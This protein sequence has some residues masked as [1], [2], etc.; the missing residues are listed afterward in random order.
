MLLRNLCLVCLS[1]A[2]APSSFA[3]E[4]K[5]Q[6]PAGGMRMPAPDPDGTAG[7]DAIFDGK[8]LNGWDGDTNFWRAEG[9]AIAGETTA[10]KP[11]KQNTFLIWRGGA[12]KDFELKLEYRINSTNSGIQ[13][14]SVEVP[15]DVKWVLKGY[16]ADIDA[17]NR[18]TGQLYEER[19]RGF[20]AL[21][22]QFTRILEPKKQTLIGSPGDGE[23]LKAFIKNDDWNE[24]HVI[25][26][27]NNI[28]HVMNG[29]VMSMVVDDDA[30]NRAME[31]LLGFQLH[32]GPPMKV[33]FR[34]IF[35][36]KL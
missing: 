9:G 1:L 35:L 8:T 19:G 16:Q 34:K 17:Q 2:L 30:Q 7:F 33:E 31:G 11:L 36:R 10:A 15:G 26:R 29:H 25:A 24:F 18:Y 22:G 32:V 21:R 23:A 12:P 20:L 5:G 14:R 13:Y 28:I 3:Q 27:A 4:K 6:R